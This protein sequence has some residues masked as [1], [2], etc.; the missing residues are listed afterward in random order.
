[1]GAKP[2]YFWKDAVIRWLTEQGHKKSIETDKVHLRG[3]DKHLSDVYL[4]ELISSRLI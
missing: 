2:R 1:L 4:D 3:L